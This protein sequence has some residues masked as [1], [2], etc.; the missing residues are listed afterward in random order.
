MFR[1]KERDE[2]CLFVFKRETDNWRLRTT[3][4]LRKKERKEGRQKKRKKERMKERK[5][6]RKRRWKERNEVGKSK[7]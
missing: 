3:K 5:K 6:E 4:H 1:G 7:Q 2:V